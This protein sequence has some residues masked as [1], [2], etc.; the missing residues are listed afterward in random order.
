MTFY[1]SVIEATT[2]V[3]IA[4]WSQDNTTI[5]APEI[6]M[7]CLTPKKNIESGSRTPTSGAAPL[8]T[9][10]LSTFAAWIA[11]LAAAFILY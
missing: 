7:A 5:T 10:G 6:Q 3:M 1:D 8:T 11:L 9:G 4:T 2:P